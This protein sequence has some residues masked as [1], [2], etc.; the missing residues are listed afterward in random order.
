MRTTQGLSIG[1]YVRFRMA[2]DSAMDDRDGAP[3]LLTEVGYL[4][5]ATTGGG[6]PKLTFEPVSVRLRTRSLRR[7]GGQRAEREFRGQRLRVR[8]R[9]TGRQSRPRDGY[10]VGWP[11]GNLVSSRGFSQS[12]RKTAYRPKLL[13]GA[14][15]NRT[16]DL[17]NAIVALSQLSYGPEVLGR[18]KRC[19]CRPFRLA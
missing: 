12:S 7:G 18:T 4:C 1:T 19:R 2:S 5:Q 11:A 8:R 15:G 13:G 9:A 3:L 14:E 10:V 6:P 16:P 17:Y